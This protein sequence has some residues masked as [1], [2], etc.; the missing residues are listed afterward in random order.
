MKIKNTG[1]T[2]TLYRYAGQVEGKT[3]ETKIGTLPVGTKPAAVPTELTENLTPREMRELAECLNKD[4]IDLAR[5]RLASLVADIELATA[6]ITEETLD[7]QAA[8]K[9]ATMLSRCK[10][11][12]GRVQR[13]RQPAVALNHIQTLGADVP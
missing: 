12:V 5:T 4:Q 6:V 1:K 10:A 8:Q 13:S 2:Y 9:L 11:A 3:L 7:E